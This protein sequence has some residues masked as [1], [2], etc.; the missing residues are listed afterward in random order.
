MGANGIMTIMD[1]HGSM[2]YHDHEIFLYLSTM[3]L[4]FDTILLDVLQDA[5]AGIFPIAPTG[6]APQEITLGNFVPVTRLMMQDVSEV[7]VAWSIETYLLKDSPSHSWWSWSPWKIYAILGDPG[8]PWISLI[9]AR[10]LCVV[11]IGYWVKKLSR[12]CKELSDPIS[13]WLLQSAEDSLWSQVIFAL[14]HKLVIGFAVVMATW[15]RSKQMDGRK[16]Q[17]KIKLE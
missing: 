11:F 10:N 4:D 16:R 15:P 3:K 13:R 12:S 14:I 9:L 2:K 8:Y 7:Y 17:E 5:G 6:A 1:D